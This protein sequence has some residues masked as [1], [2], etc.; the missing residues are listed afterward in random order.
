MCNVCSS[1]YIV[2]PPAFPTREIKGA[3]P[4]AAITPAVPISPKAAE[5]IAAI[6]SAVVAAPHEIYTESVPTVSQPPNGMIEGSFE[7]DDVIFLKQ[8]WPFK[9]PILDSSS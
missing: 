3:R 2:A 4:I 9:Y 8:G 5:I 6:P 1:I 7:S